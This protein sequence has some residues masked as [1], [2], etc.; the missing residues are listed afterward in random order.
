M[1]EIIKVDGLQ[2]A[3]NH[4]EEEQRK[5]EAPKP[6]QTRKE[7]QDELFRRA[8]EENVR[9]VMRLD[10]PF[11]I[12]ATE[13]TELE[14]DFDQV[15]GYDY[16]KAWD[17]DR[18]ARSDMTA[19]TGKKALA[20][21]SMAVSKCSAIDFMDVMTHLGYADTVQATQIA[22]VFTVAAAR[23]TEGNFTKK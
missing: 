1:A 6:K 10:K 19:M 17:T 13:Y 23:R 12:G 20:L 16:V 15:T 7:K 2:E 3:L 4:Q 9:G 21:F 18:Q 5:P 22:Q 14:W 8:Y 11:S